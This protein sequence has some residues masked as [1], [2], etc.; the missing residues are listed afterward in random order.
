MLGCTFHI[1]GEIGWNFDYILEAIACTEGASL[2]EAGKKHL[3]CQQLGM[4][5]DLLLW[6][7]V[8]LTNWYSGQCPWLA[9][10]TGTDGIQQ[11]L[12]IPQIRI[13]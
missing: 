8:R 9:T 13:N 3:S 4:F 6:F 12:Q 10:R 5:S 2:M 11:R 1:V 7:R